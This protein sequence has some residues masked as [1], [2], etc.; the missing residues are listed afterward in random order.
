MI[1]KLYEHPSIPE[2]TKNVGNM[3]SMNA[4]IEETANHIKVYPDIN[5]AVREIVDMVNK[6]QQVFEINLD[7]IKYDL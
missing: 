5:R 3:A 6:E 7:V 1:S 4:P 2:R